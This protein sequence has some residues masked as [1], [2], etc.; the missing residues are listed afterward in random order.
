MTAADEQER[1][2]AQTAYC[3]RVR[4]DYGSEAKAIKA[5]L[6]RKGISGLTSEFAQEALTE[7]IA[8]LEVAQA[9]VQTVLD[10]AKTT[11]HP[12]LTGEQF[13]AGTSFIRDELSQQFPKLSSSIEYMMAMLW[14]MPRA[15]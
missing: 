5:L 12:H 4:G 3:L 6:R 13:E 10:R 1:T 8:V 9:L 15:R 7:Q 11:S 14:H 2:I